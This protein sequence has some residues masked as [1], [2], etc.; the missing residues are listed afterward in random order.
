MSTGKSPRP[1]L[2]IISA[3][4]LLLVATSVVSSNLAISGEPMK[5]STSWP[6]YESRDC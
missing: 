3:F 6:Y 1:H 2:D 5:T 4:S